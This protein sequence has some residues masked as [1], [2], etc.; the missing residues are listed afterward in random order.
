MFLFNYKSKTQQV[1]THILFWTI[2]LVFF[3]VMSLNPKMNFS[4]TLLDGLIFI[5]VDIFS[6][7]IMIY[8]LIPY[9]L[10][11]RKYILFV[12]LTIL[13]AFVAILMNMLIRYF[14]YI[15][16]F[17]PDYMEKRV[18]WEGNLWYY[19]VATFTVVSFG[20][21]VKLTKMWIHEQ[22][23]LTD[24][25]NQKIKSELLLLK[26]QINPH[27]L[28]NTLNNIDALI[29]T[30]PKK[31]SESII[32]LSDILRYVTY[33]AQSD[34]VNIQKEEES[35]RSFIELNTLRFGENFIEYI[36]EINNS[37]KLIA[38]MLLIPLVENAIKHGDK[39]TEFPAVQIIL[40]VKEDISFSVINI[41]PKDK[42]YKDSVGGVGI[43]N[44]KRRLELMYQGSFKFDNKIIDNKYI[45]N[46][47]IR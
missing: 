28:F 34:F 6:T 1:I 33:I 21:G 37:G 20:A 25:E 32:R 18:F 45:V 27:F 30:N 13:L 3:S 12:L 43:S 39:K 2:Y 47:W 15:P 24:M 31:A 8:L 29:E 14:I 16:Y 9:F 22:Q 46:L 17:Y 41:L 11:P 35:L 19:L 5:P 4:Q 10:K 38:P 36:S 23:D 42:I 44:L 7:Y 40:K 26:S